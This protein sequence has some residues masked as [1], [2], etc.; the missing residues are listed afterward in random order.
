MRI[1]RIE[2][3]AN[4]NDRPSVLRLRPNRLGFFKAGFCAPLLYQMDGPYEDKEIRDVFDPQRHFFGLTS[5]G[6]LAYHLENY[7]DRFSWPS[8]AIV[9]EY[10]VD[11]CFVHFSRQQ[12]IF[13][14]AAAQFVSEVP[15]LDLLEYVQ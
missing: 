11:E 12:I 1:L 6:E 2:V 7:P 3:S 10:E 8:G 14:R 13:D 4:E 9:A 15:L 5:F